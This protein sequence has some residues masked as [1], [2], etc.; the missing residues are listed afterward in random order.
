MNATSLL[1][2]FSSLEDLDA[3]LVQIVT[4][5]EVAFET[6]YVLENTENTSMLCITYNVPVGSHQ[7]T[8]K[9]RDVTISL[10]RK[11][12][13]NTLYTI[14]A[15]NILVA[16]LNGG[17]LDKKFQVPWQE[18]ANCILV[19]A[20]GQLKRINTKLTRIVKTHEVKR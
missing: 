10:H 11:K 5:Y 6:I 1:C 4:A 20:Y 18:F 9:L 13:S 16:E 12:L 15:L 19:T 2:T 17:K 14:N 7:I 3:T 8:D